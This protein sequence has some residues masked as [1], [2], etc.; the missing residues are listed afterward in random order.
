M[1]ILNFLPDSFIQFIVDCVLIGGLG[2]TVFGITL[3]RWVPYV[4]NIRKLLTFVGVILL[5]SG[6]YFKGGYG[7]EMEWRARAAELQAKI[8]AAEA[9]SKET[10]IVIQEKVVTKVKHIK[11]TQVKIQQQIVEKE[12]VINAECTI[13]AEAIE[14]LNKA[15]EKPVLGETK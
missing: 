4:R 8:D 1:W 2:L 5:T 6:A 10:N 12:H 9:K 11:D 15:A 14:L 13:P 7:V 3:A